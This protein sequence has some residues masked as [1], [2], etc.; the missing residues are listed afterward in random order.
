MRHSLAILPSRHARSKRACV[1][2]KTG[3]SAQDRRCTERG[4]G[5][6][7]GL[8]LREQSQMVVMVA[9][10]MANNAIARHRGTDQNK[11]GRWRRR[12]A[13]RVLEATARERPQVAARLQ[14]VA[15]LHLELPA[16]AAAFSLDDSKQERV[17]RQPGLPQDRE[18]QRQAA[19]HHV[20]VCCTGGG[21]R[22]GNRLDVRAGVLPGGAPVSSSGGISATQRP[23]DPSH[24]GQLRD[25]QARKGPGPDR[26]AEA[27]L[28]A[29]YADWRIVDAFGR[30]HP[31]QAALVRPRPSGAEIGADSQALQRESP[32]RGVDED[33]IRQS[34]DCWEGQAGL[35]RCVR[36][37]R[38]MF[39]DLSLACS[40]QYGF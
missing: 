17:W 8:R 21:H 29:L 23:R 14:D 6:R 38:A 36:R 24:C 13:D 40:G 10:G 12:F 35:G 22:Q 15:G 20:P 5:S 16:S 33:R 1:A 11:V 3:L 31:L 26:A 25:A 32:P 30:A 39:K 4:P 27:H 37:N 9:G 7:R 19:G 18:G 2:V 28:A 34:R